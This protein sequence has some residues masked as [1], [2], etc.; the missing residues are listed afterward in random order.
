MG[1]RNVLAQSCFENGSAVRDDSRRCSNGRINLLERS[2]RT[3]AEVM[4]VGP[5]CDTA[6]GDAGVSSDRVGSCVVDRSDVRLGDAL[7]VRHGL[8]EATEGK[9]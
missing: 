2:L 6:V 3:D 5:A 9:S 8:R 1:C 4:G 7:G